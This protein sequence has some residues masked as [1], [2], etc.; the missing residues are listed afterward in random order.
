MKTFNQFFHFTLL[1]ILLTGCT[2]KS[3]KVSI[4]EILKDQGN[5]N[6][7]MA[8][9]AND[10]MM[11]GEMRD[12]MMKSDHAMMMMGENPEMM[13]KMMG[14]HQMMMGIMKK[15]ST[16]TLGMMGNMMGMMQ[17]DSVMCKMMCKMMDGDKHM[18]GM[19]HKNEMM[20]CPMH[21]GINIEIKNA[22]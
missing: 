3:E 14:N 10:H 6:E 7:I 22:E 8:A 1:A 16:F 15:D 4:D 2:N 21:S 19:M 9:I 20:N 5:R 12:Q 18:M 17:K 13:K 11:M